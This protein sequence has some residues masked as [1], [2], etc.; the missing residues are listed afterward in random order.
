MIDIQK[1]AIVEK[2][3][4]SLYQNLLSMCPSDSLYIKSKWEAESQQEIT[5]EEWEVAC[6]EAHKVTNSNSWREY[7]WKI[8]TRFFETPLLTARA[9]TTPSSE[10]WRQF[11]S[12]QY[13][14]LSPRRNLSWAPRGSSVIHTFI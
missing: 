9:G 11:N 1:G 6:E 8:L 12:I 14:L 7:Q 13:P 3:I 2:V 5:L 10:C 4:S